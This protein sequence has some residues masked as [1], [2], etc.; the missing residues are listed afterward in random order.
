LKL[1]TAVEELAAILRDTCGAAEDKGLPPLAGFS[2]DPAV[3]HSPPVAIVRPEEHNGTHQ[4]NICCTQTD[5]SDREQK[6]LVEQWCD[7]L[8]TMSVRRVWFN[9]KVSQDMFEAA[10]RIPNIEMLYIK[11]G[12]INSIQ[13][14]EQAA[15]LKA[16]YLG[17]AGICDIQSLA[18]LHEL[19]WLY[20]AN[21][22]AMVDLS[23]L[24]SLAKLEGLQLTGAEFKRFT[25]PSFAPFR[26]LTQLL[27]LH[28][29][30][31]HAE[32]G[33][34]RPLANLKRLLVL[35]LGNFFSF[36]EFAWLSAHLPT[37]R[38]D[39]FEPY[40]R[41]HRTVFPCQKCKGNWLVMTSGKGRKL[42]CPTCDS[43]KL[44][45]HIIAFNAAKATAHDNI[46]AC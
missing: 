9:S 16:F 35:V 7:V 10:C 43:I 3:I 1:D 34:L 37:T 45:K 30:A 6:R 42:L 11:W 23:P 33:S 4:I 24:H 25:I 14:I 19:R 46:T 18:G 2:Y 21:V 22:N 36:Q 12:S 5:L 27:W 44:A 26:E 15:N 39:W 8:P 41:F 40:Q 31:V 20:L 32:D 17:T 29:G 28:L 13:R 38:C